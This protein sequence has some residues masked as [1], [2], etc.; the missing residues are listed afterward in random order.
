MKKSF[1]L[2]ALITLVQTSFAQ[3]SKKFRLG[4]DVLG[5]SSPTSGGGA[6]LSVALEPKFNLSN[7]LNIGLKLGVSAMAKE[8]EKISANIQSTVLVGLTSDYYFHKSGSFAPFIGVGLG[9]Y[10]LGTVSVDLIKETIGNPIQL[11]NKLG[12]LVRVGFE[13]GKF[14]LSGELNLL[15]ETKYGTSSIK[16]SYSTLSLGFYV[17][18]G[19]WK[20][21]K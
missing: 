13:A 12:G 9:Q 7:Q 21:K 11:G 17:G 20:N 19:K 8:V 16:N 10:N 14:R 5:L 3:Q 1:I 4:F 6:G 15:P 2:I 18:G